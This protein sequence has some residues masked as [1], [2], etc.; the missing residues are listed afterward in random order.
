M[1]IS[2]TFLKWNT[3]KSRDIP[4]VTLCLF[5]RFFYSQPKY[6]QNKDNK[7]NIISCW[8]TFYHLLNNFEG[9]TQWDFVPLGTTLTYTTTNLKNL[10]K[11]L[12]FNQCIDCDR[13]NHKN[14]NPCH[15]LPQSC[16]GMVWIWPTANFKSHPRTSFRINEGWY[17]KYDA[18]KSTINKLR[19]EQRNLRRFY[20][21]KTK[22]PNNNI[23]WINNPRNIINLYRFNCISINK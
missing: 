1:K 5:G 15:D 18:H 21:K 14:S 19:F 8:K 10:S 11:C 3:K 7:T 20:I 4:N 16:R 23:W 2:P 17:N 9:L 6:Y 22:T 12:E 13:C